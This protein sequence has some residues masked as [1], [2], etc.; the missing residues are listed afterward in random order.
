MTRRDFLTRL[1]LGAG[2]L[3]IAPLLDL[4]PLAAPSPYAGWVLHISDSPSFAFGFTGFHATDDVQRIAGSL[5]WRGVIERPRV[6]RLLYGVSG[7]A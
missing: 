4:A 5:I 1:G 3:A 2:I 6:S 7:G